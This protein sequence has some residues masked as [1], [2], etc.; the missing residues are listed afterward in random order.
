MEFNQVIGN[1][2]TIRFFEPDIPVE[3]DKIQIMLEAGNRSSRGINRDFL[4]TIVVYRDDV[5]A[6]T[7]RG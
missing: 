4:K 2:R 6:E 1:R 3:Q 7:G 5:P